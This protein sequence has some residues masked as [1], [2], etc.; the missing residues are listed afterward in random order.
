VDQ[1]PLASYLANDDW[2]ASRLESDPDA[3]D[4]RRRQGFGRAAALLLETAAAQEIWNDRDP[5]LLP[6]LY[7]FRHYVELEL[8]ELGR[9]AVAFGAGPPKNTHKLGQLWP[10]VKNGFA[11]CFPADDDAIPLVE[12]AIAVL[13][14]L[15]PF[16]DGLRYATRRDGTRSIPRDIYL[17]PAALLKLI[18][19]VILVFEAAESAFQDRIDVER[20]IAEAYR[21]W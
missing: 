20:E 19:E 1:D 3:G 13:D 18:R 11:R 8:K 7:S 2:T 6:A 17:D 4:Y 9:D 5:L 12:H 16:G 10:A 14:A 21:G 15:D